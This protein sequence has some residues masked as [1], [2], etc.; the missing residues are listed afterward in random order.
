MT[1][2]HTLPPERSVF[3]ERPESVEWRELQNRDDLGDESFD[4]IEPFGFSG[5][6]GIEDAVKFIMRLQIQPKLRRRPEKFTEPQ[7]RI[8]CDRPLAVNDFVDAA[9]RYSDLLCQSVLRKIQGLQKFC[10]QYLAGMDWR[11]IFR[12]FSG[13]IPVENRLCLLVSETLYHLPGQSVFC[14]VHNITRHVMLFKP[15]REKKTVSL[16]TEDKLVKTFL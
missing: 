9:R 6:L 5:S 4:G 3:P 1:E 15:G 11:K 16:R 12:Q 14:S 8:R 13:T 2:A 7:G 10:F